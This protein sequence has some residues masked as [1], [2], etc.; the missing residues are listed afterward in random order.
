[1]HQSGCIDFEPDFHHGADRCTRSKQ[2]E[3]TAKLQQL[4]ALEAELKET[5]ASLAQYADNDPQ[6]FEEMSA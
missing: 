1:M 4:L 2:A 5:E 6:R 3:R